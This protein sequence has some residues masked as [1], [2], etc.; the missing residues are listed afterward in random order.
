VSQRH[1]VKVLL[2]MQVI[3]LVKDMIASLTVSVE[4]LTDD[5]AISLAESLQDLFV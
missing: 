2:L 3:P 1:E 5:V 4:I